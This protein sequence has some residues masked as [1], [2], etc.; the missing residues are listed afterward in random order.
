MATGWGEILQH[1]MGAGLIV[2]RGVKERL[3]Q[4]HDPIGLITDLRSKGVKGMMS[5]DMIP[6]SNPQASNSQ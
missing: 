5:L 4:Y 3:E 6:T 2:N 1:L